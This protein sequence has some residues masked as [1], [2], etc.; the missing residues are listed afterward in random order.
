[1]L[2]PTETIQVFQRQPDP[3]VFEVG[4]VIFQEGQLGD[5]MYGVIEGDVEI[6]VNQKVV[7]VIQQGGVFGIGAMIDLATRS[8]TAIAKTPCKLAYLDKQRFLFAIQETPL[9]AI[10]VMRIYSDRLSR[11]EHKLS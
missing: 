8:Y 10:G 9:F 4:Q 11:I 1:M 6:V 5:L 7:E 2:N 3:L